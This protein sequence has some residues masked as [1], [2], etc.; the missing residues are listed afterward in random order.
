MVSTIVLDRYAMR[1][2]DIYAGPA[3]VEER[4]STTVVLPGDTVALSANGNLV[5]T[6][7]EAS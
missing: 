2:G 4:E 6:V 1:Q 7:G 5:I 3:L